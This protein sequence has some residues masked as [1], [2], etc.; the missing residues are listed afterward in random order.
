VAHTAGTACKQAVSG[1][2]SWHSMLTRCEWLIQLAQHASK[3]WV[4]HT[5]GTAC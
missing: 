4:A 1:S 2:Y 5:A 3:L